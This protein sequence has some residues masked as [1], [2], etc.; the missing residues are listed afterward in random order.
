VFVYL[1][2]NA[3]H[4]KIGIAKSPKWRVHSLD[5]PQLP[6]EV[7]LQA[8]YNAGDAAHFVENQLHKFFKDKHIRGEWFYSI[9]PKQFLR[10]AKAFA[11]AYTPLTKEAVPEEP[12]VRSEDELIL[13]RKQS[14]VAASLSCLC[15]TW[16]DEQ[17]LDYELIAKLYKL[18]E[19]LETQ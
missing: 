12:T 15:A 5:S 13:L 14:M 11:K 10:N 6:F 18:G 7:E 16:N 8:E 2:G 4:C 17:R 19:A 9:G 3:E 1:I